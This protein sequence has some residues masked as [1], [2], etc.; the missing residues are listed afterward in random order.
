MCH[1]GYWVS[2]TGD[3]MLL[4]VRGVG[5]WPLWHA[6]FDGAKMKTWHA[7]ST[8]SRTSMYPSAMEC[9]HS[10]ELGPL[11]L[12]NG[13]LWLNIWRLGLKHVKS[14]WEG[15]I[16]ALFYLTRGE[17]ARF[18]VVITTV[19]HCIATAHYT[20]ATKDSS[21]SWLCI[22]QI[23]GP[24]QACRLV[25]FMWLPPCQRLLGAPYKSA[26]E[27][28]WIEADA[29]V[30]PIC[31]WS[32]CPFHDEGW[33][34]EITLI[35]HPPSAAVYNEINF[36]GFWLQPMPYAELWMPM[37]VLAATEASW[38]NETSAGF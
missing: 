3:G 1:K 6:Q 12:Q 29:S 23:W 32:V 7:H 4:S 27:C 20:V 34:V 33:H 26:V 21:V 30:I 2:F 8:A 13:G 35:G 17:Q 24:D 18:T 37:V 19:F 28:G 15:N 16:S 10:R 22:G 14:I 36:V 38:C 9:L 25:I 5:I 31:A 11:Y